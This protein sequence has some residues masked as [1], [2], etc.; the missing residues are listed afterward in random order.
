MIARFN[1]LIMG[2]REKGIIYGI[3]MIV[4]FFV[5]SLNVLILRNRLLVEIFYG[6]LPKVK[7]AIPFY[8]LKPSFVRYSS[9]TP[10]VET[11]RHFWYVN[12]PG[13]FDLD[14]DKISRADFFTYGGPNPK[15]SCLLC[16]KVEWLSRVRQK[17]LFEPHSCAQAKECESLC[18]KQG[19]DLYTHLHQNF[20]FSLRCDPALSAPKGLVMKTGKARRE[21]LFKPSVAMVELVSRRR[22]AFASQ[23]EGVDTLHNIDW[24][25]YDFL[26]ITMP[27][28]ICIRK[29]SRPNIPVILH[30]HDWW[31]L[32]NK[33]FQ[34]VIDWLKPD[35]F[36]TSNPTAWRERC[37]FYPSTRVVFYPFFDS[38]FFARPNLGEK[39][40]DLLVVGATISSKV[41][42][43][44]IALDTQVSQIA[45]RY[46]IEFSHLAG[47]QNIE[48]ENRTF[49]KDAR[50][51]LPMSFLNKWSEYLGSAKYVIFGK[52]KYSALTIKH[53]EV[54]GSGAIP[55]FP[56]VEDLNLLGIQAFE[57]Y[58]P[59]SEVEGNNEKLAYFLDHYGKFR[60][61]AE[62]AVLWYKKNSDKMLFEDF[63]NLIR[64]VTDY[65]YPRR[66]I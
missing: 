24:S 63:E 15:F 23:I 16:Q 54:L 22:F 31:P 4:S 49:G 10:L 27:P 25:K 34:W 50:S 55:I 36:L 47:A 13:F 9:A 29:F 12:Q 66:R 33:H 8:S 11:A 6:I 56:E 19:N 42:R 2:I 21:S 7:N 32:G 35:I 51:G 14:G 45:G 53:Y 48:R 64:E 65:K 60:Y 37:V 3:E 5:Q 30:A 20:D 58:I 41:Y 57:H 62:N 59:L 52:M 28:T 39:A 17:N 18:S 44:R 43:G 40:L 26:F 46:K 61:I 1:L 38:I